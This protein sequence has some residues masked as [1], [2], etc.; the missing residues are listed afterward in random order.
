MKNKHKANS[1][2]MVFTQFTLHFM[3]ELILCKGPPHPVTHHLV[4]EII[5]IG[6]FVYHFF[7]NVLSQA[8]EGGKKCERKQKQNCLSI[9]ILTISLSLAKHL[10][11]MVFHFILS[12]A[13][14]I[15][16]MNNKLPESS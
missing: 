5:L 9:F 10:E 14:H 12:F 7:F 3:T 11:W 6:I 8:Q 2:R 13:P 16:P 15:Q 4:T 1:N